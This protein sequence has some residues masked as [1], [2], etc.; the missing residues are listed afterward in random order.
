VLDS[1][2]RS[3]SACMYILSDITEKYPISL[4]H[5]FRQID[6]LLIQLR[7]VYGENFFTLLNSW[8]ALARSHIIDA[9]VG[10]SIGTVH[11]LPRCMA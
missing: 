7:N 8:H 9:V 5:R 4:Y 10:T 1:L 2:Q 6:T 3:F 11:M